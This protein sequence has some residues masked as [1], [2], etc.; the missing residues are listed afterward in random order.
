M[1]HCFECPRA[2]FL[3]P[4][5]SAVAGDTSITMSGVSCGE[6]G[7]AAAAGVAIGTGLGSPPRE[8]DRAFS[9]ELA[10]AWHMNGAT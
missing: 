2:C 9:T 7:V 10:S 8:T 3:L 6:G 1:P 5:C 4:T